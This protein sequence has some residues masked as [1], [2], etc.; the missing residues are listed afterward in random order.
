MSEG[1]KGGIRNAT[2]SACHVIAFIMDRTAQARHALADMRCLSMRRFVTDACNTWHHLSVCDL[3]NVGE[4]T[5]CMDSCEAVHVVPTCAQMRAECENVLV[6]FTSEG[7]TSDA[8][9]PS[10]D[11][12]AEP[13]CSPKNITYVSGTSL[14][15]VH[16]RTRSG[17]IGA[18]P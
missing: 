15:K 17:H 3:T 2:W 6:L 1:A 7:S 14:Q 12:G 5:T 11:C 18:H 4:Q 8:A 16:S 10:T 9:K 13:R